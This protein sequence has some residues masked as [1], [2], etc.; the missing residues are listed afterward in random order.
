MGAP[1]DIGALLKPF[2][3]TFLVAEDGVRE[4]H[5]E[6]RKR[7]GR[8]HTSQGLP[9]GDRAPGWG[10]HGSVEDTKLSTNKQH[11]LS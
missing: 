10:I 3:V 7:G 6:T 9:Q 4:K 5:K 11:S 2:S 1:V 8:G